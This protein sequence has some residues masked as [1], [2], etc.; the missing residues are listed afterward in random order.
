MTVNVPSTVSFGSSLRASL[1]ATYL[2][3]RVAGATFGERV[4]YSAGL[5]YERS[6]FTFRGQPLTEVAAAIGTNFPLGN[7]AMI[8]VGVN[9]GQR[10]SDAEG[11][12]QDLF[13]RLVVTVS[14]GEQWFRPFARD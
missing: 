3:S 2:G 13:G 4:G 10:T 8:D 11:A 1:G 12:L 5:A 6:S 14:I 9:I 7:A